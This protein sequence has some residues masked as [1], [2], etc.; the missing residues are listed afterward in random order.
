MGPTF[1]QRGWGEP[2]R[3]RSWRAQGLSRIL[4]YGATFGT[5]S[6]V[7]L[8]DTKVEVGASSSVYLDWETRLG[9]RGCPGEEQPQAGLCS[10]PIPVSG[11]E[12]L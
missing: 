1:P 11:K 3:S 10:G 9:A 5:R 2:R 12:D 7:A 6:Q 4:L 8:G